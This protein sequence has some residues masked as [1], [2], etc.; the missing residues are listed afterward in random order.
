MGYH[1]TVKDTE[2]IMCPRREGSTGVEL[3]D[4]IKL[5]ILAL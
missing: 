1:M 5:I 2:S 3:K 4:S